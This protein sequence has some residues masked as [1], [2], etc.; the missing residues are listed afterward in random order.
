V[1]LAQQQN[2]SFEWEIEREFLLLNAELMD[3]SNDIKERNALAQ[4][5]PLTN[6]SR[7]QLASLQVK[8]MEVVQADEL[9]ASFSSTPAMKQMPTTMKQ[10][11]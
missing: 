11:P 6:E 5:I 10:R 7:D 3:I 1:F 2:A 4:L 8:R 9:F